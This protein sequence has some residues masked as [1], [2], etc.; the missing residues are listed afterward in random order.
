MY[1]RSSPDPTFWNGDEK[2]FSPDQLFSFSWEDVEVDNVEFDLE[3]G[4]IVSS[5]QITL[6]EQTLKNNSDSEQEM[7]FNVDKNVANSSTFKYG[8]GFTATI[9]MEFMGVYHLISRLMRS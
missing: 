2:K 9:G 8:G 6:V 3:A 4:K 5:K 7:N 1:S